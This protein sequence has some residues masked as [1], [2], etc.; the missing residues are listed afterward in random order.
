MLKTMSVVALRRRAFIGTTSAAPG[1]RAEKEGRVTASSLPQDVHWVYC[2]HHRIWVP[3]HRR[4]Y[5]HQG[6]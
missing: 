1:A 3:G 2:H 5:D 6:S 4:S